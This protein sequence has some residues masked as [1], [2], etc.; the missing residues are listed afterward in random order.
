MNADEILTVTI[1]QLENNFLL[2]DDEKSAIF[3]SPKDYFEQTVLCLSE[4]RNKYYTNVKQGGG[5]N[6]FHANSYCVFL[7][8]MSHWF[9]VHNQKTIADKIYYMNK[10]LN[11]VDLYHE[12]ELPEIWLCEHPL[13]TVIGRGKFGNRFFFTQRCGIGHN[14]GIYPVIG[15]NVRMFF[16]SKIIGNSHIGDNVVVSATAYIKDQDV[17]DNV[18]VFGQSPNLIFKPNTVE[19]SVWK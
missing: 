13:G 19:D 1:H 5:V 16:D 6:P 9:S 2:S 18:I 11:S 12:V 3:T 17:P 4:S 7:Y 15:N 10:M 14:K 8:W